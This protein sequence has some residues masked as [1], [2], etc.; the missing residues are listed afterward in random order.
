MITETLAL[1]NSVTTSVLQIKD[2]KIPLT[3]LVYPL[4][5][6]FFSRL[7]IERKKLPR[8]GDPQS[9]PRENLRH[10]RFK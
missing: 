2:R 8:D 1:Q 6:P 10:L 9:F 7:D 3:R 5:D 4:P